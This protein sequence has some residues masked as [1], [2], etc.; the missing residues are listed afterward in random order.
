VD[1]RLKSERSRPSR[2]SNYTKN[3]LGAKY[4]FTFDT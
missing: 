4:S 2:Y 3:L 1:D